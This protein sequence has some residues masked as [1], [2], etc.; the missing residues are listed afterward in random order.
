MQCRSLLEASL[1]YHSGCG[2][3]SDVVLHFPGGDLFN[4]NTSGFGYEI[5]CFPNRISPDT[6]IHWNCYS[7]L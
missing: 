2:V 1:A 7:T 3:G 6:E 4:S 5:Q